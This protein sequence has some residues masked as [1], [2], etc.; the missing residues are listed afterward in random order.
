MALK[1]CFWLYAD[2]KKPLWLYSGFGVAVAGSL[3]SATEQ[4]QR[5]VD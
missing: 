1:T 2:I 5:L 3:G 4:R